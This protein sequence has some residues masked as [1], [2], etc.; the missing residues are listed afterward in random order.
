MCWQP[1]MVLPRW[2]SYVFTESV[3]RFSC[4][5]LLCLDCRAAT[6]SKE[7]RRIRPGIMVVLTSAFSQHV[8]ESSFE[9]LQIDS[10]IQK[11]FRLALLVELLESVLP[12]P[13]VSKDLPSCP[14]PGS[15]RD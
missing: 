13:C 7:A 1:Q 10:F 3:S 8:A 9:G 15:I 14:H 4:W 12:R 2:I 11:P 6:S 5:M